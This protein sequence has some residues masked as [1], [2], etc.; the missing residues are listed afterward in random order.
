MKLRQKVTGSG[1]NVDLAPARYQC[2]SFIIGTPASA[3]FK[4]PADY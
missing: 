4:N 3:R 1:K 2:L